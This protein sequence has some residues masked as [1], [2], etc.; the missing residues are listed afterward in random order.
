M[1]SPRCPRPGCGGRLFQEGNETYC[2][3]CG[4]APHPVLNGHHPEPTENL[5]SLSID[6]LVA[7]FQ[8]LHEQA[9][10]NWQARVAVI[11]ELAGRLTGSG[12]KRCKTV[13]GMVG[14]SEPYCRQLYKVSQTFSQRAL[15]ETRLKPSTVIAA[16]YSPEPERWLK[17]AEAE[18][19]TEVAVWRRTR[20]EKNGHE[21]APD[22]PSERTVY[23]RCRVCGNSGW[24]EVLPAVTNLKLLAESK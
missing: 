6:D 20:A 19:L 5:G 18:K 14:I 23:A 22:G 3:A 4:R 11:G 1:A 15:R 13:A 12:R 8:R 7:L 17:R 10:R 21:E 16:A 24:Q 2:F 9:Q